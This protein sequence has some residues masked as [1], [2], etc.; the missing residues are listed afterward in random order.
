M[1]KMQ[2]TTIIPVKQ[3]NSLTIYFHFFIMFVCLT[4]S[5]IFIVIVEILF[6]SFIF[7]QLL[8]HV[9]SS[10]C[11]SVKMKTTRQAGVVYLSM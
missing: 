5:Y 3:E 11:N 4:I 2:I 9:Q 1:L 10:N 8:K 7:C 6:L